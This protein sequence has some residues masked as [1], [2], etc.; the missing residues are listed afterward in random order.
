MYLEKINSPKDI[1]NLTTPQL[2]VLAQEMRDALYK[3]LSIH[4]G[5]CGP[6]FGMVE[7][8]IALHRVFD[9][10]RDKFVFDVSHQTYTHKMLTG[11]NYG[12][13]DESRYD[14][15]TG[16]SC[17]Q[18]SEHDFFTIGHTSTSVSLAC[19]LAKGRDLN[20]GK[21]N[22]VAI[23]GDGSL[24]GGEALEGLDFASELNS[25]L[26]IV[27]N[28]NDM[29]I[30]E[31]HGGL[32][33][34]LKLLRDTEG[35]ADCN[36][37]KSMGL[38]YVFV[39]DGND[40]DALTSAFESVKD[41]KKPVVVHIVTE[42]GKGFALAEKDKENWHWC[43]PFDEK[44][45]KPKFTFDGEDYGTLTSDYLLDK[46][47]KD[48]SVVAITS[49]TPTVFGFTKDKREEAGA[50]FV[51]VGI[52]EETAV[53]LMSGISKNG[54]KPV[55]GVYSTFIQRTFDQL[56][57]DV[58]INNNPCTIIVFA[59]S[60]FGMN[61]VTHLG[62][63]DI[64][65]M[66]NIPN[67][68]YL[69]PTTKEEYLAML[70]WSTEQREHPVA[71][72]IPCCDFISTG[73]KV[74]K[75]FSVLNKYEIK[76]QG[77]DVAF[78]G[79]GTFYPLAQSAAKLYEQKTG[80]KATVI[81]PYYITG[82]DTDLLESLKADHKTVVTIEDGILDGGF[83]EKIA[84]FYGN[85]DMRVLNFGLKKEFLDRYDVQTVLKDNKLTAEQIVDELL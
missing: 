3:K 67:L 13:L 2:E 10:P 38:D 61:D 33:K 54:G 60:V 77:T 22:I 55:Y 57:Q 32:Y 7:A 66:S 80:K 49:A 37:F 70:D 20:G 19:G 26:I 71:I 18:E 27:V 45:G 78:I 64:P 79:L 29:S 84:R 82:V 58:C 16:Y 69:A 81:N 72:R 39:K 68:V 11:R 1:K 9:S 31:N 24:S 15:I 5:H 53:A 62:I 50:Q 65:M 56:S 48:K 47:K 6:N 30:A 73:E 34:N 8:T 52:A 36:F 35:K 63:Y 40:I 51:D 4:G 14:D 85:S 21:E 44:T 83:G 43:M 76:E 46:M 74:T 17:P 42:K 12:F 59:A 75:D 23:I 25:N 41:S 28:D